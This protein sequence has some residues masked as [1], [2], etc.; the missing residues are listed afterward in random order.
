MFWQDS[1]KIKQQL[2]LLVFTNMLLLPSWNPKY[3]NLLPSRHI[4]P[5]HGF[6]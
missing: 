4:F 1:S 6:Y 5:G 2:P 3:N